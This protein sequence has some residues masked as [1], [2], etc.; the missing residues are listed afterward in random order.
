MVKQLPSTL[1][2]AEACV[3]LCRNTRVLPCMFTSF[4]FM[5]I[6]RERDESQPPPFPRPPPPPP[7][8]SGWAARTGGFKVFGLS[9]SKSQHPSWLHYFNHRRTPPHTTHYTL[10]HTHTHTNKRQQ[11]LFCCSV[12]HR[13]GNV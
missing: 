10:I 11:M 9:G 4:L 8:M 12:E 1:I 5:L 3:S 13:S 7:N 6:G 2:I